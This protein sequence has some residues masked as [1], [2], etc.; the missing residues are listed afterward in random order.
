MTNERD[1]WEGDVTYE[2]WARGGNIDAIDRDNLQD[3]YIEGAYPEEVADS[4]LRGQRQQRR[5]E[6]DES[7]D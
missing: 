7:D 2:V 6:E 3:R 1:D 5:Y 4:I